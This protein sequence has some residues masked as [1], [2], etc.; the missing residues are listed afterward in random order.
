MK[1]FNMSQPLANQVLNHLVA[2][3]DPDDETESN[4]DIAA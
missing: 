2:A 1:A 3:V 4:T